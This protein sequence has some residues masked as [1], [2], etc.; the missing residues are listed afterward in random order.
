MND[1]RFQEI[2]DCY[3]QLS[4][5]VIGDYCLDRYLEIDPSRSEVSIET[6]LEVFNVNNVRS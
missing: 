3:P 6:G 4:V 5:A 1:S 2:T